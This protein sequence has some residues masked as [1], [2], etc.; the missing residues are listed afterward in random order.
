MNQARRFRWHYKQLWISWP[1]PEST[2][3]SL[4]E[5][6]KLV[7]FSHFDEKMF[8]WSTLEAPREKTVYFQELVMMFKVVYIVIFDIIYFDQNTVRSNLKGLWKYTVF[9]VG[10]S[11]VDQK[12]IFS[13]KRL[14]FTNFRGSCSENGVL[15]GV[16]HDV[17]SCLYRH[18]WHHSFRSKHC[19][20]KSERIVQDLNI[21]KFLN[22]VNFGG[23]K[24]ENRWK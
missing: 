1:T 22:S 24:R 6:L 17:Q 16:G 20:I 9:S 2:P 7:K 15:S 11:K 21:I 13:S 5:A 14:N 23:F 3:F 12:N 19:S 10:A 18:F 8:F 4:Q